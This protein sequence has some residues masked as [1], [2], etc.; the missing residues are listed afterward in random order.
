M[1]SRARRSRVRD[2]LLEGS[3]VL[4]SSS[5]ALGLSGIEDDV[6]VLGRYRPSS[7]LASGRWIAQP[8]WTRSGCS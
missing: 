3:A 7:P 2:L 5:E 1:A 4:T 6:N 8:G